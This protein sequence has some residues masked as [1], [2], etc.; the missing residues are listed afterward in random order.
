MPQIGTMW[1]P[2]IA[3]RDAFFTMCFEY[4]ASEVGLHIKHMFN[5][6]CVMH[7]QFEQ[8]FGLSLL[9]RACIGRA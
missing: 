4:A 8:P 2:V 1:F 5:T 9:C 6:A 3:R 7:P